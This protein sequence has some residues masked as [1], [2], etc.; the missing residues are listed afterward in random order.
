MEV[1]YKVVKKV[2][3]PEGITDEECGQLEAYIR[4]RLQEK[5]IEFFQQEEERLDNLMLYGT[6][7]VKNA[8]R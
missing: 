8:I 4:H 3:L 1:T 7:G 2:P 5:L 6:D